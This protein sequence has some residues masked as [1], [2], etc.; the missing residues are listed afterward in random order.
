LEGN[1]AGFEDG[2]RVKWVLES[3]RRG[4][5][6]WCAAMVYQACTFFLHS[7]NYI[8]FLLSF[9]SGQIIVYIA[10]PSRDRLGGDDVILHLRHPQPSRRNG[11]GCPPAVTHALGGGAAGGGVQCPSKVGG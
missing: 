2:E 7:L 1:G 5:N 3:V 9:S 10:P 4:L 11:D 8:N 6:E